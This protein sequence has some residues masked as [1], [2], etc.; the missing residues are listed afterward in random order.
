TETPCVQFDINSAFPAAMLHLPC[1]VHG[2]WERRVG[3]RDIESDELS[4]CFL[5]FKWKPE[6]KRFLF[7]GFPVRRKDG[8]IHFP[9]NGKGWYW[10]FEARSAIHQDVTIYDSW[11][12]QKRC[13]CRPFDF[14]GQI[15]EERKALG[16][17]GK[18]I[19]LK[20]VMNSMYGK[21]VQTIGS[22]RY[23]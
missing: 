10:S 18:G 2:E 17:S 1:L 8:S 6:G 11:V 14:L 23:S 13:D 12:Y 7:G 21:L 16:K 4:I 3:K 9:F 19:V 22:P 20:L 5:R 15:Y